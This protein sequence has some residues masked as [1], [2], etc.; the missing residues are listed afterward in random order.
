MAN[1]DAKGMKVADLTEEQLAEL[2]RAEQK[3]NSAGNNAREIYLLAVS[4]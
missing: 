3:M 2:H 1:I 4:R